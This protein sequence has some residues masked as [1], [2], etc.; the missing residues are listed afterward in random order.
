M[1]ESDDLWAQRKLIKLI[2]WLMLLIAR[3]VRL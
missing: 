3:R 1:Q 2:A